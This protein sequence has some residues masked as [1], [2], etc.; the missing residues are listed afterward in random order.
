MLA[1]SMLYRLAGFPFGWP[2]RA[3]RHRGRKEFAAMLY[4]TADAV[5]E[6]EPVSA[7]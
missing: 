1:L 4:M 6:V 2:A 7:I 3:L 5:Y